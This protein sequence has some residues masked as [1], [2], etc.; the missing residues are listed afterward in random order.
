MARAFEDEQTILR[1][2]RRAPER[3]FNCSQNAYRSPIA[4]LCKQQ[5]PRLTRILR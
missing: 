3:E 2:E 4:V 5:M 1:P